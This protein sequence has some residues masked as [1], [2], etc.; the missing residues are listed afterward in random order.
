MK[1]QISGQ[2][3]DIGESLRSHIEGKIQSTAQKFFENP[4]SSHISIVKTKNGL[5]SSDIVINEGTGSGITIKSEYSDYD[6]YR[7]FDISL[8][9]AE[10]QLRKHKERIKKH[11]K[12]KEE[13]MAFMDARNFTVSPYND[14]Q[15]SGAPAII[16]ES[17]TQIRK[18]SLEDAIMRMDLEDSP[19]VVFFN[20]SSQ[21]LNV[22]YYRKDGNIAWID[23]PNN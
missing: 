1:I 3:I 4:V 11:I 22:L 21:R 15:N 6:A 19:T 5:I 18:M 13:I 2:H 7:S 16:A 12:N 23:I 8:S 10:S 9:R 17:G 20:T 14:E